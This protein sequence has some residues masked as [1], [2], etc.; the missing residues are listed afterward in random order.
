MIFVNSMADL[1]HEAVP[2]EFIQRVFT[3]MSENSPAHVP[4]PD[5]AGRGGLEELSPAP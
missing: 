2:L 1:F 4:N 5:E 3:T